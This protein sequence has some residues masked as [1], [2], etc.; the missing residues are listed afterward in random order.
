MCVFTIFGYGG[1]S[2]S[3][4]CSVNGL[5][6]QMNAFRQNWDVVNSIFTD[7]THTHRGLWMWTNM[8]HSF[9]R[10][11]WTYRLHQTN[12]FRDTFSIFVICVIVVVVFQLFLHSFFY[13]LYFTRSTSLI[14]H[15]AFRIQKGSDL[16]KFIDPDI[17]NS[18]SV[19]FF[20]NFEHAKLE[21]WYWLKCSGRHRIT[22]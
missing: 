12:R 15:L 14:I 21:H 20:W 16:Q 9:C 4:M 1:K 17:V 11:D 2:F 13:G 10:S 3:L 8:E 6:F 7:K 22:D 5:C 18:V 19:F